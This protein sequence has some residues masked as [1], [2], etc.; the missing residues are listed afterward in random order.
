MKITPAHD[1]NDYDCGMRHNLPFITIFTPDGAVNGE[2][3]EWWWW[4]WWGWGGAST[5][6]GRRVSRGSS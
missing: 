2:G 4:R 1:P 3:G 5:G 6:T